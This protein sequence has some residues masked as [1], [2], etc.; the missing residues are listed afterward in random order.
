MAVVLWAFI[1]QLGADQAAQEAGLVAMGFTSD[2]ASAF[3]TKANNLFAVSQVYYG[4]ITQPSTF[5][6]DDALAAVRGL[7]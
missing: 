6:Y 1:T 7:E 3:W 4:N 5:D 2:D